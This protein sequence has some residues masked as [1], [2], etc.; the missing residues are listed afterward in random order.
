MSSSDHDHERYEILLVKA[1]DRVITADEQLELDAHLEEC[2][3]CRAE[4]DDFVRIKETTDAMAARITN[5]AIIEPPREPAGVKAALGL[6]F[7]LLLAGALLLLGF[8]GYALF[9]DATV[10]LIVKVGA[11]GLGLGTLVLLAYV[12]RVRARARRRDPYKEIDL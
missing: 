2:Q 10:P 4:L 12:L 1:V 6:G 9:T 7:F 5:D 3:S 8:A 11:G